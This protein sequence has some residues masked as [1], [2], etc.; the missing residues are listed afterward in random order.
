MMD[1]IELLFYSCFVRTILY[2]YIAILHLLSFAT[3]APV[4]EHGY[5][6]TPTPYQISPLSSEEDLPSILSGGAHFHLSRRPRESQ[7]NMRFD[8][9]R[10]PQVMNEILAWRGQ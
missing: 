8:T 4:V 9:T 2:T 6:D 7:T 10:G 3:S 1:I 5:P